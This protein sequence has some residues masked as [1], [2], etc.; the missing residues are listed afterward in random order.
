MVDTL[1]NTEINTQRI[2]A[3]ESCFGASGQPLAMPG[4]VLVGE[5]ILTKECRKKPKPRIFFLFTDILVYGSIVINKVRYN[6][7]HIIPLED[8]TT[9]ILPD[10][11]DMKNRW[12][13]KTS[14]KSFVVS[15]ASY[16]ERVEWIGHINECVNQLLKKTGQRR[17]TVHA[18]A[19]IPDKATDICMRCTE[20]KFST[21]TR[22]HHCR[23]C[24]FV[25]CQECSKYKFL[26]PFLS[27]KP[28]RVCVLCY[29]KLTSEKLSKDNEKEKTD[30]RFHTR[31][32]QH[33]PSS[34]DDSEE[35]ER[36]TQ[37]PLTEEFYS[38]SWSAFH[39]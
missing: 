28:S 1:A 8:I 5:G 39:A 12:M 36:T 30:L 9:E 33:E 2:A 15:A 3:V 29:R 38:T 18:A 24:G 35:D 6:C 23:N 16:T 25:V 17:P 37:W 31:A 13:L 10:S 26:I 34:D 4:R 32:P 22:R 20:T 11:Q 27:K 14:K 21:L 19:W 7:Q